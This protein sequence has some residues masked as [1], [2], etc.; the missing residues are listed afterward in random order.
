MMVPM[1]TLALASLSLTIF[2]VARVTRLINSD[3]ITEAPRNAVL[4][5]LDPEGLAA[6]LVVCPW[7]VSVYVG[8]AGGAAWWA[9]GDT[10]IFTAS[11]LALAASHVA[12]LL[13]GLERD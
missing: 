5:R 11:V 2:A 7:C 1:Q 13:A 12:G 9:W 8:A 4:K 6:Y 3:R 10:L